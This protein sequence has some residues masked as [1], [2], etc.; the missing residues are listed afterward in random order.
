MKVRRGIG[1][2]VQ[3]PPDEEAVEIGPGDSM[4]ARLPTV[5]EQQQL[6]L[7]EGVW[8]LAVRHADGREELFD[9]N[10]TRLIPHG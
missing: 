9:A 6:G 5:E 3:N 2:V 1:N 10:R 4:T 8:V 7:A